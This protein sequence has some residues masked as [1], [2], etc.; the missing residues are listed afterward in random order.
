MAGKLQITNFVAR[1]CDVA[2]SLPA[3][4][5]GE[6]IIAGTTAI[7]CGTGV[8]QRDSDSLAAQLGLPLDTPADVII[9]AAKVLQGQ[10]V[11]DV[12]KIG[13]LSSLPVWE[14]LKRA[15]DVA[16]AT[17]ALIGAA[18]AIAGAFQSIG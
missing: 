2:I 8:L 5:S 9:E 15:T 3:E 4:I 13:T 16:K 17:S 12:E 7:N 6:V 11:S 18:K 10:N 14:Y 1:D